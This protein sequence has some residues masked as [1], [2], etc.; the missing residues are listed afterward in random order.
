[1]KFLLLILAACG[2]ALTGCRHEGASVGQTVTGKRI[3]V[4]DQHEILVNDPQLAGKLSF[5]NIVVRRTAE[6][7]LQVIMEIRNRTNYPQAIEVSTQFRDSQNV[8][9]RDTSA[10]SRLAMSPNETR[11]Y[12]ITSLDSRAHAFST[13][14][15]EGR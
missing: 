11:A 7:R 5:H 4:E 12:R 3:T 15:R 9:L 1:M 6:N 10:W 13:R 8:P 2:L 14:V